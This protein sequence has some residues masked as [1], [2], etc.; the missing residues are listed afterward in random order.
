M[1]SVKG[2]VEI[3]TRSKLISYIPILFAINGAFLIIYGVLAGA[4]V[5]GIVTIFI[6]ISTPIGLKEFYVALGIVRFIF[7]I[8]E[9]KS[10]HK[11]GGTV[12]MGIFFVFSS[13][14]GII[15]G[16]LIGGITT[17]NVYGIIIDFIVMFLLSLF[18]LMCAL[19]S[20]RSPESCLSSNNDSQ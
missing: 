3:M 10:N 5:M 2:V 13:V 14:V 8:G 17:S 11:G 4:R 6:N 9:R 12:V 15:I 7:G 1:S 16:M 20:K 18:Y 19:K